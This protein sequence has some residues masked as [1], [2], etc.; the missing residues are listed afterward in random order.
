ML[1]LRTL[2]ATHATQAPRSQRLLVLL[3]LFATATASALPQTLRTNPNEDP[4]PPI[5]L[6]PP[7]PSPGTDTCLGLSWEPTI[8]V[9]PNNQRVVAAAQGTTIQVSFDGGLNFTQTL[10]AQVPGPTPSDPGWCSGGDPS[11]GFDSQGR[12]YLTYLGSRLVTGATCSTCS[13]TPGCPAGRDVFITRW[14]NLGNSFGLPFGPINVTQASGHGAPHNADKEWLAIDWYAGSSLF[15]NRIYV[16]WS[17]IDQEPWQI[18]TTFSTD[19]G[20]SW[21]AA[22]QISV[23]GQGRHVWPV[24]NTVAP[25]HD[26]YL[27]Y[28]AQGGFLDGSPDYDVP[29]GV[30]GRVFVFRST[31]GGVSYTKTATNPFDANDATYSEADMT[32]NRQD[33]PWGVIP[34][35]SYWLLGSIQPWIL[36]DP[37]I[38]GRIYVVCSDDPDDDIT[39]G[40]YADVVM[41][42]SNDFGATWTNPVK[43]DD[44]PG[45]GFAILP[46]A[47][48][49]PNE[50][51]IVVTWFEARSGQAG[52]SGNLLLDL[53]ARGSFDGGLSWLPSIDVNDD[54]FDPGLS[55]NCR[56]CCVAGQCSPFALPTM[57]I[58]EYN[59]VA[60]G[61]CAAHMVWPDDATC[62]GG[63]SDIFYDRDSELG[64]DLT[65]P[66][67]VCP[68]HTSRGC[69]DS[70]DP[71]STGFATA[72]DNCDLNPNVIWVDVPMAGNCPPST[73]LHSIQRIWSATDQ[74][75]NI[76]SCVQNISVVD[77]D[78]PV[79]SVPPQLGLN[80]NTGFVDSSIAAVQNWANAASAVDA[81]SMATLGYSLPPVFPGDVSPGITT[82]VT[83]SAADACGNSDF[84]LGS[85]RIVVPAGS[86][87]RYC[88][89][90]GTGAACP[91]G[92]AGLPLHGC[93]TSEGTGGVALTAQ[94][95]APD[96]LGGGTVTLLATNFPVAASV[97]GLMFSG[98]SVA[99][100]GAGIVF[101]DGLL[102]VGG[103]ITRL[104]VAFSSNGALG[105]PH[106]HA[107]GPGTLHYQL[108]FRNNPLA[109]CNPVAG[110]N[111]SNGVSLTW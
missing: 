13:T 62:G 92:N 14:T 75:G 23:A 28:H 50:G 86:G 25:N 85:V 96:G 79:I 106:V 37:A 87:V 44:A 95:F 82:N 6:P 83:F 74:A 30:S 43:V 84:A 24:H 76:N 60:F 32:Y 81:C 12:L 3:T 63:F 20:T 99:G 38:P 34:Q 66:V 98:T 68:P 77:F 4:D 100:G 109:F 59:G 107:G 41:A 72:T 91:C 94:N 1:P 73:V 47:A 39:S 22:Q 40:D 18:W 71:T 53:R 67:I 10:N 31:N 33:K 57:R 88:F 78:A 70:T 21:S 8:A 56:F 36:A 27:A 111:F 49:D 26:V 5:A 2:F 19:L 54:T 42:R 55:T 35:A 69:N 105:F 101:G 90:T 102:C 7:A 52:T 65:P 58:G 97:P 80:S 17:D 48:I 51:A 110:Y 15:T 11:I 108:W 46:T 93:N 104:G 16:A 9:D 29:D 61:E 45:T 64:G 89:G 103:T